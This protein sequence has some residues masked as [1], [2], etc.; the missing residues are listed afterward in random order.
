MRLTC[1]ISGVGV[2]V[3]AGIW[4]AEASQVPAAPQNSGSLVGDLQ[5]HGAYLVNAV[6]MCVK[7]HTPHD[8]QG[9]PMQTKMLQGSILPIRPKV[10][11]K[12]WADGSPDITGAG[13]AG[14]W[15][16]DGM[17]KF[18]MTGIDP[19]GNKARAPMP[20]FRLNPTDARA[21]YIYLIS[22]PGGKTALR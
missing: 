21:V 11:T 4:Y 6:G 5:K 20:P 9:V 15:T 17:V 1:L 18:L 14:K 12:N 7:C 2:L 8:D 3:A 19:E 16:E 13:L 10:E 22:L